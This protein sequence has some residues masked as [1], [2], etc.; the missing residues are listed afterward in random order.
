VWVSDEVAWYVE[1]QF[2]AYGELRDNVF[3]TAY[4][5]PRLLISWALGLQQHARVEGP[6]E[7]AR[8]RASGST[9]SPSCTVVSRRR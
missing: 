3:H 5:V 7:L 6:P 9:A 4:A 1:R 8:R 2:G